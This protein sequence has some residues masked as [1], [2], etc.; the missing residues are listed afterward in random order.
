MNVSKDNSAF[1][2]SVAVLDYNIVFSALHGKLG[3][4]LTD[5]GYAR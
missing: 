2:C 1:S 3:S 5:G 4:Q